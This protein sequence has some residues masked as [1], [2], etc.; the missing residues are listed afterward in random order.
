MWALGTGIL[1]VLVCIWSL[2]AILNPV[3]PSVQWGIMGI[4][5]I[6]GLI[7]FLLAEIALKIHK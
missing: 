7:I 6:V 4:S 2:C 5:A 3:I 1:T